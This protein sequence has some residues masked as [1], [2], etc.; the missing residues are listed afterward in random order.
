ML[1]K[2]G[3]EKIKEL[4][5]GIHYTF[6]GNQIKR[7]ERIPANTP[8]TVAMVEPYR[9]VGFTPHYSGRYRGK[10]LAKESEV[11]YWTREGWKSIAVDG[12]GHA[13]DVVDQMELNHAGEGWAYGC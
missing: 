6:H 8:W 5:E 7:V 10:G 1:H 3:C 2:V 12:N 11:G 13:K 9:A 4:A